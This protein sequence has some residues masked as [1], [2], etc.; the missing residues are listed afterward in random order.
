MV[1]AIFGYLYGTMPGIHANIWERSPS[2]V[3]WEI[4]QMIVT[5][6]KHIVGSSVLN[7][8]FGKE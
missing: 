7:Q 6:M 2:L 1:V 5:S 3:D 8:C 4:I